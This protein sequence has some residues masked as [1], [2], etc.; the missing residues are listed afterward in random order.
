MERCRETIRKRTEWQG[1]FTRQSV[2]SLR[3]PRFHDSRSFDAGVSLRVE[4]GAAWRGGLR[5]RRGL[6]PR[7]RRADIQIDMSF[8]P[9]MLRTGVVLLTINCVNAGLFWIAYRRQHR[10][11]G[12][13]PEASGRTF[14]DMWW[15]G[16]E[17]LSPVPGHRPSGA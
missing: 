12:R 5:Q 2:F 14:R 10:R 11:D 1:I 16:P 17:R 6:L 9:W 3:R 7:T 8:E 15:D 13:R 4:L